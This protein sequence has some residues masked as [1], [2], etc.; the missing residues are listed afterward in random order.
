MDHALHE[1]NK[2]FLSRGA[3]KPKYDDWLDKYHDY[4][5]ES[6][7]TPIIDLGCGS[8]NDTLYLA[9]RGYRVISC[10]YSM[11]A[12]NRLK[13]FI[14][15]PETRLFNMLDG[16]PFDKN[17]ACVVIADLSIHY[18]SWNDTK[19]II[20]DIA[21]VLVTEGYFI[22]R[23][24]SVKDINYGA[25][26]GIKLEDNFYNVHG[27]LKRF[28]DQEQLL[29]LFRNWE[30]LNMNEYE[31]NRYKDPKLVWEMALKNKK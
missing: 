8:G 24:N 14:E 31:M 22:C 2:L 30:I 28:F 19:K 15:K 20:N 18:F 21:R 12:L 23:V 5:N 3:E 10:D 16:L 7:E 17:S 9:E 29:K 11:E 4:L 13:Y 27:N 26:Q 6:K 25:G 1:W